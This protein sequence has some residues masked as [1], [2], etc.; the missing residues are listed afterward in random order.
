MR[1]IYIYIWYI[2]MVYIY[3]IYIYMVYI[4]MV[5]RRVNHEPYHLVDDYN[6]HGQQKHHSYNVI[7]MKHM[8]IEYKTC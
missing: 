4:Y 6:D 2:Y 3:G 8:G 1:Y 7:V 5:Y